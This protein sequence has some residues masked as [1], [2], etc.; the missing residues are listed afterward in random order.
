ML[1]RSRHES[2]VRALILV[3]LI[4]ATP[5]TLA[6][7]ASVWVAHRRYVETRQDL[8]EI[9]IL[10]N[11]RLEMALAEIAALRAYIDRRMPIGQNDVPPM[12]PQPTEPP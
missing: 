7:L 11:S 12:G 3:A 5:P 9:H 4:A 10:V 2:R 6:V 8:R 1:G